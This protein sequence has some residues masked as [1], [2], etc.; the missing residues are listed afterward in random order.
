MNK[1]CR[2]ELVG[3]GDAGAAGLKRVTA[4]TGVGKLAA[5]HHFKELDNNYV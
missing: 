3:S 2:N 1:A 4:G 5:S